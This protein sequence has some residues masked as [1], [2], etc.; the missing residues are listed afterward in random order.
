MK[1][2]FLTASILLSLTAFG[3]GDATMI[4]DQI[5]VLQAQ[6]ALV[7]YQRTL[8]PTQDAAQDAQ[9]NSQLQNLQAALAAA[10]SSN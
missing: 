9:Y 1:N 8:R 10:Q 7:V 5:A 4:Q 6:H 2:I 3:A